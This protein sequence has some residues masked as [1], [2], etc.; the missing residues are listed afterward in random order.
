M[1]R[2]T[3]KKAPGGTQKRF[4]G[5]HIDRYL[6]LSCIQLLRFLLKDT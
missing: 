4:S 3:I 6:F 5:S 1:F 2:G